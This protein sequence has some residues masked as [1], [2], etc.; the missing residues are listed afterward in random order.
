MGTFDPNTSIV[1]QTF[2]APPS[3]FCTMRFRAP[4][5]CCYDFFAFAG[6]VPCGEYGDAIKWFD[7][8]FP[9]LQRHD[10]PET[11]AAAWLMR[12]VVAEHTGEEETA[13]SFYLSETV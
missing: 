1:S 3:A 2:T 7:E 11:A 10:E 12:G 13:E 6:G 9:I 8:A 4:T 5:T